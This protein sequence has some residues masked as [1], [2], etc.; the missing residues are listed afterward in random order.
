MQV[1]GRLRERVSFVLSAH[2]V[3]H[4]LRSAAASELDLAESLARRLD[5]P[6]SRTRLEVAQG[7]NLQARARK[8]RYRALR[9]SATRQGARYLVTAHHADDRAETVLIRLLRGTS[10]GGLAVLRPREGNL[11]RPM[12]RARRADVLGH[13]GRHRIAFAEDPSNLDQRF[14]RVRVRLELMPLLEQ[15]SP[16]IVRHLTLLADDDGSR[17]RVLRDSAGQSVRL[18]RA[19]LEALGHIVAQRQVHA[20]LRLPG[21]REIRLDPATLEPLVVRST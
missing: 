9:A 11:L 2:G 4:G 10:L 18:N 13:L 20:R 8:A 15:L 5:I 16:Q 1:L 3:D 6:F 14:L 7:A 17:S 19:Q 12:I 21:D